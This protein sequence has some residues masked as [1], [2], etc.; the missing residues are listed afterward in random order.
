MYLYI[1][2]IV[3][4]VGLFLPPG[5]SREKQEPPSAK[6]FYGNNYSYPSK[7][8]I[9]INAIQLGDCFASLIQEHGDGGNPISFEVNHQE[10]PYF[11]SYLMG[12]KSVVYQ[13]SK[14]QPLKKWVLS[15]VDNSIYPDHIFKESLKLNNGK[16]FEALL[17]IYE[18]LKNEARYFTDYVNYDSSHKEKTLFFN[19]FVDIR[20]DLEERDP[21]NFHGDHAGSWYRIWGMMLHSMFNSEKSEHQITIGTQ[22]K[23]G[24]NFSP[25]NRING[26]VVSTF[27]EIVKYPME[28]LSDEKWIEPDPRKSEINRK[29][30]RVIYRMLSQFE[31][32]EVISKEENC[33]SKKYLRTRSRVRR[34]KS[35]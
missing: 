30:V 19:K 10:H 32:E 33:D 13:T 31:K 22:C 26:E 28:W 35:N 1:L 11:L 23:L 20:G 6:P 27:A 4:I 18:L 8:I 5:F 16:V 17:T 2:S 15:Q 3:M 29:G 7:K 34:N 12:S 9:T 25:I 21:K 24:L 14:E